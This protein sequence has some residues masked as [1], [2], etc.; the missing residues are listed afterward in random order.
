L[1]VALFSLAAIVRA[2]AETCTT[3]I[4]TQN[5]NAESVERFGGLVDDFIVKRA[6]KEWM[7]MTD[8]RSER[9]WGAA[10]W[11]PEN[12]FETAGRTVD[13]EAARIVSDAHWQRKVYPKRRKIQKALAQVSG[14]VS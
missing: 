12:G 13:K 8:D 4:E 7:R 3:K 1:N 10:G 5:W 11:S 6:T 14:E 2:T 9:R